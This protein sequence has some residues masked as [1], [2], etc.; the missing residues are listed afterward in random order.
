MFKSRKS[1]VAA[2]FLLVNFVLSPFLFLTPCQGN[3]S[4]GCGNNVFCLRLWMVLPWSSNAG[5]KAMVCVFVFCFFFFFFF[6]IFFFVFF[7]FFFF[8]LPFLVF[9]CFFFAGGLGNARLCISLWRRHFRHMVC[10]NECYSKLIIVWK[11]TSLT[12]GLQQLLGSMPGPHHNRVQWMLQHTVLETELSV[13]V[14]LIQT[15]SATSTTGTFTIFVCLTL[16]RLISI[17]CYIILMC[18]FSL[19]SCRYSLLFS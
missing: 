3:S 7:F 13:F 1:V 12:L 17:R 16:E 15:I 6:G 8:V 11:A 5:P 14:P 19:L 2:I 10:E 4:P 18:G 9:H